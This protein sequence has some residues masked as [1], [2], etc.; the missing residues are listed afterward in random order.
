MLVRQ[1]MRKKH[2]VRRSERSGLAAVEFAL[3]APIFVLFA[4]GI[5]EVGRANVVLGWITNASRQAARIA[6]FDSTT[7]T[8]TVKAAA[9]TYL[10]NVGISGATTTV[11]PDPPATAADGQSVSVTVSIPFNQ[12]SWL[13]K[14]FFLGGQTLQA[15]TVMCREPAP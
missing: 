5:I 7:Q 1:V 12:V 6:S 3:V 14:A 2:R 8:A 4:V 9:N 10:S 15:T 11:S 13:P